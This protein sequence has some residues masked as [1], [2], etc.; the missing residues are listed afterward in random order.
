[1]RLPAASGWAS[2]VCM[3]QSYSVMFAFVG[4]TGF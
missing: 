3:V 2:L 1:M 4:L